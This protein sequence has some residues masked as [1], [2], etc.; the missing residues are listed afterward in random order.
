[1]AY[2]LKN[3]RFENKGEKK[4][5]KKHSDMFKMEISVINSD[6]RFVHLTCNAFNDLLAI[7]EALCVSTFSFRTECQKRRESFDA[8][9]KNHQKNILPLALLHLVSPS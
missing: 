9:S 3:K 5:R 8:M 2:K 7:S 6:R 4:E 1:M